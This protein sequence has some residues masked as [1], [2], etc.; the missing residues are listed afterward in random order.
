[1]SRPRKE[2]IRILQMKRFKQCESDNSGEQPARHHKAGRGWLLALILPAC[3]AFWFVTAPATMAVQRIA[4]GGGNGTISRLVIHAADS[5]ESP[6]A[7]FCSLSTA[8]RFND[9]MT[10][11]WCDFL[12]APETTP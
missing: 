8:K 3:F 2:L 4:A 12:Q 6:M 1:M 9:F 11:W 7:L 10:D 5:Y